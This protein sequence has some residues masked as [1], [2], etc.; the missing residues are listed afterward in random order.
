MLLARKRQSRYM[1][2][3][4]KWKRR[5]QERNSLDW[6]WNDSTEYEIVLSFGLGIVY[7]VFFLDIAFF[8][9]IVCVCVAELEN[10]KHEQQFKQFVNKT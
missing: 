4:S 8:L 9:F 2:A 1:L 3:E 10:L 7:T 5:S 6:Q